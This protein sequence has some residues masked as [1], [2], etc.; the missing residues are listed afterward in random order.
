YETKELV[1]YWTS[2]GPMSFPGRRPPDRST[3]FYKTTG[4]DLLVLNRRIACDIRVRAPLWHALYRRLGCVSSRGFV[5]LLFC[6]LSGLCNSLF[7]MHTS[8]PLTGIRMLPPRS[9]ER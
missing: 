3:T 9:G 1:D 2:P 7:G 5:D 8:S 4:V 6:R